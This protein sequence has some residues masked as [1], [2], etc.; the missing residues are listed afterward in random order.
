MQKWEFSLLVKKSA[1]YNEVPGF[2]SQ[3]QIPISVFNKVDLGA[4]VMTQI[5]ITILAPRAMAGMGGW[6]HSS[7]SIL[8]PLSHK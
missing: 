2:H 5:M 7:R 1:A 6:K 8:F 4:A 3:L